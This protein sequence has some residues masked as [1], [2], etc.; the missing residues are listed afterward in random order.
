MIST[1]YFVIAIRACDSRDC[2]GCLA[3]GRGVVVAGC[4]AR[5]KR[6]D[7]LAQDVM[8][9]LIDRLS[10]VLLWPNFV[11]HLADLTD[12]HGFTWRGLTS[13]STQKH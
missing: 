9:E 6:L 2:G 13:W 4:P 10:A 7:H 3:H 12:V 1:N 11:P 8:P 5:R